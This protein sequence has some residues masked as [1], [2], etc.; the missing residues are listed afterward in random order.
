MKIKILSLLILIVIGVGGVLSINQSTRD[1][2][3]SKLF[4]LN[5]AQAEDPCVDDEKDYSATQDDCADGSSCECKLCIKGNTDCN[6][7]C[8]CCESK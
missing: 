4:S 5:V 6:P 7:T 3:M 1:L 8:P 2:N